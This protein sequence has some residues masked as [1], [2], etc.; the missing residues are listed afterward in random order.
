M[1][2]WTPG[3]PERGEA[4]QRL[5]PFHSELIGELESSIQT[6]TP[7]FVVTALFLFISQRWDGLNRPAKE[8][9]QSENEFNSDPESTNALNIIFLA[10]ASSIDSPSGAHLH[11][12][13]GLE[14]S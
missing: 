3:A 12:V 14:S 13:S 8:N 2:G 7:A 10:L 11:T 9:V 5:P 6:L 1:I 4:K